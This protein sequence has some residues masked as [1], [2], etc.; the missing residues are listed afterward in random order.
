MIPADVARTLRVAS[1]NI[2]LG[3]QQG[4]DALVPLIADMGPPDIL[5]LQEVGHHWE[6]GPSGDTT[7]DLARRLGYRHHR[8]IPT[9]VR[10]TCA[11]MPARYGHALLSRWPIVPQEHT[12]LPRRDDEPR[13]LAT[14]TI[15][16]PDASLRFLTTHLSHLD[17]DRP[18]QGRV[19]ASRALQLAS[20]FPTTF[21][22]GDLNADGRRQSPQWLRELKTRFI[23]ADDLACRP[24]FPADD[25]RRRIDYILA[26]G[27]HLDHV[28]VVAPRGASDHRAVL[29]Q[30]SLP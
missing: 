5:A 4:L 1:F 29:S 23:D 3:I 19:L 26:C 28:E 11:P 27:A 8:F 14:S 15:V 25:P 16:H 24:T 7:D 6:M 10:H 20:R 18:A 17:S 21:I 12:L 2:R 22:V 9:I 30:W 13:V